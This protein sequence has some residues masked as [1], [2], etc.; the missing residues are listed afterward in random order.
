MEE[1]VLLRVWVLC[2]V[3]IVV[4]GRSLVALMKMLVLVVGNI[5]IEGKF[6]LLLRLLMLLVKLAQVLLACEKGYARRIVNKFSRCCSASQPRQTMLTFFSPVPLFCVSSL[7]LFLFILIFVLALIY[8]TLEQ[9]VHLSIALN[10]PV[11]FSAVLHKPSVLLLSPCT[12]VSSSVSMIPVLSSLALFLL[13][14]IGGA[15]RCV[16][17]AASVA[18][19]SPGRCRLE[20]IFFFV[21]VFGHRA[22]PRVDLFHHPHRGVRRSKRGM[23]GGAC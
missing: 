10:W 1:V 17:G 20:C 5:E 12:S 7:P 2:A 16:R 23:H 8:R 9:I 11:V 4:G 14:C 22:C 21:A 3:I 18:P 19:I 6:I 15:Q 13:A